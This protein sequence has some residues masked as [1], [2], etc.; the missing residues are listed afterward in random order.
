MDSWIVHTYLGLEIFLHHFF[1]YFSLLLQPKCAAPLG[2]M[3]KNKDGE[4][5]GELE[6]RTQNKKKKM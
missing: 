2:Y 6:E 3:G 5:F 1:Q 4:N